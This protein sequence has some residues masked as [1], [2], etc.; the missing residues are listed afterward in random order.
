[1]DTSSTVSSSANPTKHV[2][3]PFIDNSVLIRR[4]QASDSPQHRRRIPFTTILS[5]S[6]FSYDVVELEEHLAYSQE[7]SFY[8]PSR[9]PI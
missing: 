4:N 7:Y 3:D 6:M 1:M 8:A 5:F 9:S 2:V